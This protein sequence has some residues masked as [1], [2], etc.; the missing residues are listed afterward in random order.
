M[1]QRQSGEAALRNQCTGMDLTQGIAASSLLGRHIGIL[2]QWWATDCI[3]YLYQG[4][5]QIQLDTCSFTSEFL[6]F[7]SGLKDFFQVLYLEESLIF[8]DYW[9]HMVSSLIHI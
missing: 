3:R 9:Y 7:F 4:L 1:Y 2:E 8:S 5:D 6:M